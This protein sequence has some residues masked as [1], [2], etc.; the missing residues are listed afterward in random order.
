MQRFDCNILR[1]VGSAVILLGLAG[2]RIALPG[3]SWRSS[4]GATSVSR[5]VD[6]SGSAKVAAPT[7]LPPIETA[8]TIRLIAAD[9]ELPAEPAPL[10]AGVDPDA[11]PRLPLAAEP[12]PPGS[13][14][15]LQSGPGP[16]PRPL[17]MS[18]FDAIETSLMQNPDLTTL[19][20]AE[21]V[22]VGALGVA[23]TYPFNPFVQVQATPLQRTPD[24][25]TGTIYHYVLVMQ[26]V[27]LAHQQRHREEVAM[28]ALNS[29]R[30]NIL[31]AEVTNIAQTERL[32]FTALYLQG[33]RDLAEMNSQLSGD[34]Y[35]VVMKRFEAGDAAGSD[36]AVA[37]LDKL[38]VDQQLS[39]A[40]A[41]Y[42]TALLDLRR[43]LNLPLEI[44]CELT[45]SLADF[46][47]CP[48]SLCNTQ[49]RGKGL[50]QATPPVDAG[51][52]RAALADLVAGRPDVLA[53]HADMAAASANAR[54]AN[55]N[56]IPDLQLGPYYQ[57]N[58]SGTTFF[59]FRAH[60]ELPVWNN[61]MP[62]LQQR[63]AELRQRR[64]AWQQLHARATIEAQ[65]AVDRYDRARTLVDRSDG[66]FYQDLPGELQRLEAQFRAG[67]VDIL[68]VVTARTSLLQ[69][70]RAYLDSLNELAQAA[71]VVTATTAIRPES[72]FCVG[73]LGRTE[74]R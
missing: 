57:R 5:G 25:G 42:Q 28:S 48:F 3:M 34:T 24:G 73:Q 60:M 27:Q 18:L 26:T 65:A 52:D 33:I 4:R 54:L 23:Q 56:R 44:S 32:F 63:Q 1:Y 8:P 21:G 50:G 51:R 66:N 36:V 62:L 45:G 38:S 69:A 35:A 71:A 7:R 49:P 61:G 29:V 19:R 2:C 37:R 14:E 41:N 72:L 55:A 16:W 9:E 31:Q 20:Q 13:T 68:R 30:W 39:I 43:Q 53:A 59:G 15:R 17:R 58:D 22:S 46:R 67:E 11:P 74:N 6:S 64:V 40:E 47:W 70:R 12:L 10:E